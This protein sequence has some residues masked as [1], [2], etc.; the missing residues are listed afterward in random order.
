MAKLSLLVV[1][2]AASL[3]S[4]C[5][6]AAQSYPSKPLRI[7]VPFA[8]GSGADA[9]PRFYGELLSKLWGQSIVV[10]NRPGGSGIIAAQTVKSSVA[11][12]Y[13]LLTG[14]TSVI[15]V[16]PIVMK[17]LPYD[18]IKD[19]RPVILF[20]LSPTVFVV[21]PNLPGK[22]IKD[23]VAAT[24]KSGGDLV[25]G[26]Y[27]AGYELLSL[28]FGAITGLAITPV[29]YKGSAQVMTDVIGGQIASGMIDFGGA[30]PL[31]RDGRLRALAMTSDARH[32]LMPE[33]PTMKESGF[34]EFVS[35]SWS[36]IFVR[37][38]TP[39]PIVNKLHAGFR[40]VMA[41]P[42]G[43]AYQA[44]RPVFTVDYTPQEIRAFVTADA[45]RYRKIAQAADIKPR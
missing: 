31:I 20:N 35:H 10:D 4:A 9:N 22:T 39:G 11:D 18:P 15:A 17:D 14:T 42:E 13:T 8:A 34:P 30:A 28:W 43:R 27:S 45:E 44:A 5:N 3:I 40:T 21:G 32:P 26:N 37:S 36:S 19:F 6:A 24:K 38:E 23:F 33:V 2:S 7:V 29:P 16:N 1:F 25:V 12:G 41:S